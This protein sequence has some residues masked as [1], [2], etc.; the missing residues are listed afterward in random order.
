ETASQ[1]QVVRD[2]SQVLSQAPEERAVLV[3]FLDF[4]CEACAAA[5]P[6][7]EDLRAE[8]K[9]NVTFVHRYFPLPGHPNSMTAA[10]AA[11]AAA[12]QG[13]Y[14]PMYQQLFETQTEWSHTSEDQSEVFRGYAEELD[15]DMEAYDEAV[16]DPATQERIEAD[17]ADG[18]ALGVAGTPT[19]FL[20]GEP[21]TVDS[22]EQFRA[23]LD[24]AASN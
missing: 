19:F 3:E 11:E 16:T 18:E 7:V 10:L 13:A 5:Y 15:L 23:E 4:E 2:D 20:D 22:L 14:E 6:L 12:E 9:D 24:A 8:Y 17:I 21:L 1:A